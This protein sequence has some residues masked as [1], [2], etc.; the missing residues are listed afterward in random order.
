MQH[1][2]EQY[3]GISDFYRSRIADLYQNSLFRKQ[4]CAV[5]ILEEDVFRERRDVLDEKEVFNKIFFALLEEAKLTLSIIRDHGLSKQDALLEVGGGIGL[6]YG[7]LK[8]QGYDIWGI[9]PSDSGFGGYYPAATELFQVI[10]VD[11]SH[12]QPLLAKDVAKLNHQFDLIFSNNVLEHVSD[13]TETISCLSD[14]L[15]PRGAMVHNTVNYFIPYEPH[16][17]IPLVPLFP[18]WTAFFKPHLRA[19]SL[20]QGLHFITARELKRVCKARHL[21]IAFSN[22]V[23]RQAFERLERDPGFAERQKHFVA[24]YNIWKST[25]LIPLLDSIPGSLVTPITF[26]ITKT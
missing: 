13:L 8:H 9:E 26:T 7:F 16:F 2:D 20:W 6:V 5:Q 1:Q 17:K 25:G 14:A 21:N 3:L 19:S 11:D 12:F 22:G 23:L 18:R 10:G 24:I 15:K 4:V